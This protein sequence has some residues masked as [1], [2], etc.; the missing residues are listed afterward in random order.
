MKNA[1]EKHYRRCSFTPND[2]CKG[3]WKTPLKEH[4]LYL[5]TVK[6]KTFLT[7]SWH[8][9]KFPAPLWLKVAVAF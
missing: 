4:R 5:Q 8:C 1:K 2:P 9:L 7:T 6:S 3:G